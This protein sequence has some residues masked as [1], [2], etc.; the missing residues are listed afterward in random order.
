MLLRG[1]H[2]L[3]SPTDAVPVLAK[4]GRVADFV[5]YPYTKVP[6]AEGK[7]NPFLAIGLFMSGIANV[8]HAGKHFFFVSCCMPGTQ[9]L[10]TGAAVQ[11]IICNQMTL[12]PSARNCSTSSSLSKSTKGSKIPRMFSRNSS[13]TSSGQFT[14]PSIRLLKRLQIPP[15]SSHLSTTSTLLAFA[16]VHTIKAASH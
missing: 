5:P 13:M 8:Q 10:G 9:S 12:V 4:P 2:A 1:H 16:H 11:S 6:Q 15:A 3:S 7:D 14:A